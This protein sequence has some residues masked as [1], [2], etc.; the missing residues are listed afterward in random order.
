MD[1]YFDTSALVKRYD[2]TE[3]N[4]A[5]VIGFF[6]THKEIITCT[7]TDL[8]ILTAFYQ[9]QRSQ[10]Y[11]S[12]GLNAALTAYNNHVSTAYALFP[13]QVNDPE[14]KRI[15]ASYKV[16]TNDAIHVAT[17]LNIVKTTKTSAAQLEFHTA[18]LEQAAVAQAEGFKVVQY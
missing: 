16:R 8:E 4:A 17:A 18:D 2:P 1:F 11:T 6:A 15:I 5:K 12:M 9:K 3:I 14:I 7:L 13:F 10:V